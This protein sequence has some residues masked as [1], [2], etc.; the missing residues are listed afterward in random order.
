MDRLTNEKQKDEFM[1]DFI[2]T[3]IEMGYSKKSEFHPEQLLVLIPYEL[4]T[5]YGKK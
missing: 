3:V 5:V 2:E 1:D 4:I